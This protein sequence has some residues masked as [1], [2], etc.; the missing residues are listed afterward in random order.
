MIT[1][2]ASG[3]TIGAAFGTAMGAGIVAYDAK[4]LSGGTELS[5]DIMRVTASLCCMGDAGGA[6]GLPIGATYA[7]C[8]EGQLK[9][10]GVLL[11]SELELR[12]G[13][14]VGAAFQ[15]VRIGYAT[16]T[17]CKT[18]EAGISEFQAWGRMASKAGTTPVG[19][20]EGRHTVS[21]LRT[22]IASAS[23]LTVTLG[24]F[25][26]TNRSV[27]VGNGWSCRQALAAMA[28]GL[29]GYACE[30][31]DGGIIVNPLPSAATW[32]SSAD[33]MT[34]LPVLDEG[35]LVVDGIAVTAPTE[36]SEADAGATEEAAAGATG[37]AAADTVG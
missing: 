29:G 36:E 23:G 30:T 2:D 31:N 3:A 6:G 9:G 17:G 22:A 13:V 27:Y 19:L 16:V 4:L 12:V 32:T 33:A 18:T 26:S 24:A 15:Y 35:D 7:T 5:C 8:I 37:E 20:A 14:K 25:A 28:L 21:A 11:G 1:K 34:S 10:A